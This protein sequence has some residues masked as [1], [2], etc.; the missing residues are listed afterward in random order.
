MFTVKE[1]MDMS[2]RLEKLQAEY[3]DY[4][5]M[6]EVLD[7]DRADKQIW[8]K[9]HI[10]PF[11]CDYV[12]DLFDNTIVPRKLYKTAPRKKDYVSLHYLCGDTPV[13]SR[14]YSK[15][16]LRM[17]K[18]YVT[19]PDMRIEV[20]FDCKKQVLHS[21]ACTEFDEQGRPVLYFEGLQILKARRYAYES[22]RIVRAESIDDFMYKLPLVMYD[23]E[24]FDT[25][26]MVQVKKMN[27]EDVSDYAFVYEGKVLKTFTRT[28]YL[29]KEVHI[30]TWKIPR[31]IKNYIE[32]GIKWFGEL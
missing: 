1:L 30:N 26:R 27:P 19:L 2:T 18:V 29:Y 12:T 5:R 24:A 9:G 31:A 23:D 15:E 20:F 11:S 14:Y 13:Y 25:S 8:S 3:G 17:E 22:E 28:D 4:F 32:C 10:E 21:L 6:K 7:I 16:E